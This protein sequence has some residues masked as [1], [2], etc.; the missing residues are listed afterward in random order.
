MF[1]LYILC[2]TKR[3]LK[4][5][6]FGFEFTTSTFPQAALRH[7]HQRRKSSIV[8]T[9]S[10]IQGA[11]MKSSPEETLFVFLYFKTFSGINSWC[12]NVCT[13]MCLREAKA[14]ETF[15][16]KLNSPKINPL[17]ICFFLTVDAS[18]FIQIKTLKIIVMRSQMF[19]LNSC[20]W[21]PQDFMFANVNTKNMEKWKNFSQRFDLK[22]V[23]IFFPLN[24]RCDHFLF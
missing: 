24:F 7:F 16:F 9:F 3:R 13:L 5:D 21:K 20:S 6:L 19:S 2:W 11:F 17:F 22:H 4:F 10:C 1:P 14:V 18:K 15:L 23:Y 12:N 8:V